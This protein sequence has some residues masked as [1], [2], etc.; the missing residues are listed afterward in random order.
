MS[1]VK[2]VSSLRSTGI[3][4]DLWGFNRVCEDLWGFMRYSGVEMGYT[5]GIG[6]VIR[7]GVKGGRRDLPQ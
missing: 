3:C 4:G 7:E 5:C 6:G 2:S 1:S